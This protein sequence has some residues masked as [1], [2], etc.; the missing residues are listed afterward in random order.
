MV[1]SVTSS[2]SAACGAV[3]ELFA[4]RGRLFE[5]EFGIDGDAPPGAVLL[6]SRRTMR[7]LVRFGPDTR[8]AVARTMSIKVPDAYGPGADQD[9]LLASSLDGI[10]WHHA[11]VPRA[12]PAGLYSSLW[13]YLAGLRP[14]VFGARVEELGNDTPSSGDRVAFLIAGAVSRFAEIGYLRLGPE[15][16]DDSVR[17]AASNCGSGIRALPPALLYST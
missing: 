5:A 6:Q 11:V 9:F 16:S 4:G 15:R 17:F 8:G 13:L 7:A 12:H 14:V 2:A 10:P 3:G 1:S